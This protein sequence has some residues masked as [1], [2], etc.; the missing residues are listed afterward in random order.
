MP[1]LS[2]HP[3]IRGLARILVNIFNSSKTKGLCLGYLF[4]CVA[5]QQLKDTPP[6]AS[7]LNAFKQQIA[8]EFKKGLS[9][10]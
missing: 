8:D 9:G 10:K 2:R 7:D 6:P 5:A 1:E 4:T 3:F